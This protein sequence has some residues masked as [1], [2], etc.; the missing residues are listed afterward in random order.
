[1]GVM[2]R[3]SIITTNRNRIITAP[4]YTRISTTP[5][6]SACSSSHR[7]ALEKKVRISESTVTRANAKNAISSNDM[8]VPLPSAIRRVSGATRGYF[9]LEPITD[10]QQLR[11]GDD[12][13]ATVLEMVFKDV[14]LHD[15]VDRAAFFA[16][17][18]EDALEEVDV[19]ARGAA[20]AVFAR[21][22]IDG[23]AGCGAHGLAQLAGDAALFAIGIAA[24]GMQAAEAHGLREFLERVVDHVLQGQPHALDEFQEHQALEIAGDS[25]HGLI[26]LPGRTS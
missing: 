24:Q 11:L 22:G 6:N 1:M 19:V 14:R 5:R 20:A 15:R 3:S 23:D 12:V 8:L 26:K 18:T 9:S 7:Q 16:E 21:R 4:T 2:F 10:G 13:L 17:A 25:G